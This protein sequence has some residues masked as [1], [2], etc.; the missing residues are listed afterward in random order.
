MRVLAALGLEPHLTLL[1]QIFFWR[2]MADRSSTVQASPLCSN[3]QADDRIS[4]CWQAGLRRGPLLGFG[5]IVR[6]SLRFR[7]SIV[8]CWWGV[9]GTPAQDRHQQ[10]N[11]QQGLGRWMATGVAVGGSAGHFFFPGCLLN[12]TPHPIASVPSV[13]STPAASSARRHPC[14][15]PCF[16]SLISISKSLIVPAPM[17]DASARSSRDQPSKARAARSWPAPRC[18]AR[19]SVRA[20]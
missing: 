10:D 11:S 13:N 19:H 5:K 6:A 17:P 14:T 9:L 16:G 2:P 4:H 15:V 20:C 18:D 3:D 12:R 7:G 8:R 1:W